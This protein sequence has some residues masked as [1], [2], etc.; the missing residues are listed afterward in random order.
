[1][2]FSQPRDRWQA[3][4]RVGC[5]QRTDDD[6]W[7]KRI[8]RPKR[9]AR[10]QELR[11]QRRENAERQHFV[12]GRFEQGEVHLKPGHKHQE[13]FA[14]LRQEID[15][16]PLVAGHVESVRSDDETGEQQ[17]NRCRQP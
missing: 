13:Q 10:A 14:D 6:G 16:R 4:E 12:S 3:E 5:E 7:H 2:H 11:H 15:N 8:P 17:P 9:D 1:M